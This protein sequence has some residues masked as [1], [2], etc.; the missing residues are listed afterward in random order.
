MQSVGT[1]IDG[2]N[3]P[4]TPPP[5]SFRFIYT[6]LLFLIL[7]QMTALADGSSCTHVPLESVY[8][9]M[10]GGLNK[11]EGIKTRHHRAYQFVFPVA[12]NMAKDL[13]PVLWE[14]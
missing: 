14:C 5:N 6:F 7:E 1:E 11:K 10:S 9:Y 8:V 12:L 2:N 3:L 13:C 4:Q